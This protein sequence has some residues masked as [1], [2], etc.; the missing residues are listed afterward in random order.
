[1]QSL[2]TNWHSVYTSW[3]RFTGGVIHMVAVA[4]KREGTAFGARLRALRKAAELSQ[5][6]LADKAGIQ[7]N[8][9]ARLERG[10][11]E[12]TWPTV[13]KLAE[14]LGVTPDAF[15]DQDE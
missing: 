13:L 3:H 6:E 7:A 10:E 11:R 1:M 15:T 12:P 14:S 5:A 4:K 8:A 2:Y 9:I